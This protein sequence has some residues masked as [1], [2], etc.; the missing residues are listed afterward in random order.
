MEN[1]S[2][3]YNIV[4]SFIV[5]TLYAFTNYPVSRCIA[6]C[7]NLRINF[8]A[9]KS[10]STWIKTVLSFMK[11]KCIEKADNNTS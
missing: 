4:Y 7:D 3:G 8:Y 6:L 11:S 10:V 2:S 1:S 9:L 5:T